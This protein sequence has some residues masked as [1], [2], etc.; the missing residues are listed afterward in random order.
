[1]MLRKLLI[2]MLLT[3]LAYSQ[4]KVEMVPYMLVPSIDECGIKIQVLNPVTFNGMVSVQKDEVRQIMYERAVYELTSQFA[5][6]EIFQIDGRSYYLLR[7]PYTG[8]SWKY[9]WNK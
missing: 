7:V 6:N 5:S 4:H 8:V 2:A 9:E 1:M 3:V